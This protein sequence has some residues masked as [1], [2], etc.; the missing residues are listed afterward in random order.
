MRTTRTSA[1]RKNP[2]VGFGFGVGAVSVTLLS[3]TTKDRAGQPATASAPAAADVPDRPII[4]V[5]IA[6]PTV[7]PGIRQADELAGLVTVTIEAGLL[8]LHDVVAFVDGVPPSPGLEGRL[9]AGA[10]RWTAKLGLVPEGSQIHYGLLLCDPSDVCTNIDVLGT[11]DAPSAAASELLIRASA[12]LGRTAT[13][14]A[15]ATWAQPPSSDPYGVLVCGRGAAVFYGVRAAVPDA[16]IGDERRDPIARAV[17]I[18]PSMADAWWVAGRFRAAR[19]DWGPAREAFTRGVIARP[20]SV[21]IEADEAAALT[22]NGRPDQAWVAW[23][24]VQERSP[25]DPRFAVPRARVALATGRVKEAL[26]VLNHLPTRYQNERNVAELRVRI[27]EATG[28]SSNFDDLL[29]RWQEAAPGDPEPVRRRITLRV[30]DG[31]YAEALT[32]CDELAARGATNE[33]GRTSISLLVGL[34]R[35]EEAAKKADGLGMTDVA[36]RIRARAALEADPGKVPADLLAA[37]D[38]Y[39]MVAAGDAL[40]TGGDA[41]A[42]IAKAEAALKI[43]AW[44]PEA[45]D[46]DAR[47]EAA[48]GHDALAADA[49]RRLRSAEPSQARL[50]P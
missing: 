13:P 38:I 37:T 21:V 47:A 39:G 36:G 49:R 3:C 12:V 6:K 15:T 5:A 24:N 43:D 11:R 23:E 4:E 1:R 28:Q 29:A 33:A 44:S 10:D 35:Y 34:S 16:Q 46:L 7:W 30:D 41:Q 27:A 8:D 14:E 2:L 9:R 31:R 32:L 18:D 22:A 26:A 40:L 19:G 45:L 17:F 50:T 20:Q 42:A 48:A 25:D